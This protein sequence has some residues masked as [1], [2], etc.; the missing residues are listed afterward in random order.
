MERSLDTQ[1]EE[2]E[3][4]FDLRWQADQRAIKRWQGATGKS[5]TWPD[6]ADL[7]V[8]LLGR[9]DV[10][11]SAMQNMLALSKKADAE[12]ERLRAA[13]AK[14]VCSHDYSYLDRGI[15]TKTPEGEIWL[16]AR[17]AVRNNEQLGENV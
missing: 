6:H 14:L 16:E 10:A 2:L 5:L 17:A 11:E 15:G 12:I 4:G 1:L 9:V 13:L 7:C 8:W 3:A